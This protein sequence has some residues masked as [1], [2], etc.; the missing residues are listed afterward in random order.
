MSAACE[1]IPQRGRKKI[2]PDVDH[3][4]F[5]ELLR[6]SRFRVWKD[7]V[8]QLLVECK[9]WKRSPHSQSVGR[10]C[11]HRIHLFPLFLAL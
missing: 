7:A 9:G 8:W 6:G 11:L 5:L 4:R 3:V 1:Q 2:A 10:L